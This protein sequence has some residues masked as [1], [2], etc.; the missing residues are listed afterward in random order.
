MVQV[1]EALLALKTVAAVIPH[2]CL[3]DVAETTS[4]HG[5]FP[6]DFDTAEGDETIDA[7]TTSRESIHA[8][9]S[10]ITTILRGSRQRRKQVNELKYL[11]LRVGGWCQV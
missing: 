10:K 1:R 11:T 8:L 2:V 3:K 5:L 9:C 6:A 4:G 7:L